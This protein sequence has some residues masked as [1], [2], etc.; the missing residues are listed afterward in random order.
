MHFIEI[1]NFICKIHDTHFWYF[2]Q[3][4]KNLI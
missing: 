2:D 1:L 3:M 4:E